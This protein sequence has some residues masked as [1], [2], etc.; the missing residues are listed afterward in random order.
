MTTTKQDNDL[1]GCI[2][3][4]YAEIEIELSRPIKSSAIYYRN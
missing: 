3:V 1:I 2:G 4:V